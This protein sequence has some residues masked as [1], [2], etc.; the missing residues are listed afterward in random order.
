MA[1]TS[2]LEQHAMITREENS[3]LAASDDAI[4]LVLAG[5]HEREPASDV[6]R[7]AARQ[8]IVVAPRD[9]QQG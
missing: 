5:V 4:D 3:K 8:R 2:T 7:T 9:S 1:T 6:C